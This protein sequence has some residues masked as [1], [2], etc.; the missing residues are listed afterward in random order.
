MPGFVSRREVLA[1]SGAVLTLPALSV[2]SVAE[3]FGAR[4]AALE[5]RNGGRLGV[6][7]LDTGTGRLVG[8]RPDG[9]FAMCSTFNFLAAALV[10]SRVDRGEEKLDRRIVF[11]KN[12][13]VTYSPKTEKHVGSEGMTVAEIC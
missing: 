8:H 6:A 12:D 3:D 1:Y 9:R 10:L 5:S 13:L 11:S 2:P 7:V 4:I